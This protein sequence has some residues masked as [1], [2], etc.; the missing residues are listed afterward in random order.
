MLNGLLAV[1][2]GEVDSELI[3]TSHTSVLLLI[4]LCQQAEK[5][6]LKLQAEI[7]ELENRSVFLQLDVTMA[8]PSVYLS[9]ILIQ[10]LNF[11]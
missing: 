5:W 11:S 10:E 8:T 2:R 9:S 4:Q 1:V 3:H 6:H 7:S